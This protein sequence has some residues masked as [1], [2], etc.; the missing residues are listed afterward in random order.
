MARTPAVG[1]EDSWVRLT[2]PRLYV[3]VV[4]SVGILVVTVVMAAH[5]IGSWVNVTVVAACLTVGLASSAGRKWARRVFRKMQTP[6]P[7]SRWSPARQVALVVGII[8]VVAV[9]MS[10]RV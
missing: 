9:V 4:G 2:R 5:G 3:L 1:G 6:T 10:L 8:F 7:M